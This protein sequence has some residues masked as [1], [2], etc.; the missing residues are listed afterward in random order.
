VAA[1]S[2]EGEA[3]PRNDVTC[4][5]CDE[6]GHTSRNCPKS[7]AKCRNCGREGHIARH[8]RRPKNKGNGKKGGN[9]N[10]ASSDNSQKGAPPS[11]SLSH[12]DVAK[13][14]QLIG[15]D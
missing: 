6:L 7:A 4:Y 1:V 8:C 15:G 9:K 14:R 11:A 2:V 10:N 13:L 5:N 12:A 3:P